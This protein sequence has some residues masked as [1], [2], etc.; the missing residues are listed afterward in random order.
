MV[1]TPVSITTL[2]AIEDTPTRVNAW[3]VGM[4]IDVGNT[5]I[6]EGSVVTALC[7]TVWVTVFWIGI[8]TW[9]MTV[10]V[11]H[12][13]AVVLDGMDALG[14]ACPTPPNAGMAMRRTSMNGV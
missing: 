12:I 14:E 9:D 8:E 2:V 1:T 3:L 10:S 7:A 6:S 11:I 13:T 5:E 4:I